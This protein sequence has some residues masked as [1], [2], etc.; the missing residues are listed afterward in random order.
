M[1]K[2]FAWLRNAI[3]NLILWGACGLGMVGGLAATGMFLGTWIVKFVHIFPWWTPY[4][5]IVIG[6]GMVLG[7]LAKNGIPERFAIYIPMV[8]PSFFLAI[9]KDAKLHEKMTGWITDLNHWLDKNL[10]EWV[11]QGGAHAIMT[12]TATTCIASAIFFAERYASKAAV[13]RTGTRTTSSP[14]VSSRRR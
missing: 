7:D 9:P 10:G 3:N 11:G 14:P 4:P 2:L 13:G 6:G 8:W 1:K 12:I 5:L